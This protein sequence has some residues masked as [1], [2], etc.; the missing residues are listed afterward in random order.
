MFRKFRLP[1]IRPRRSPLYYPLFA[2][3]AVLTLGVLYGC[4][5]VVAAQQLAAA[6]RTATLRNAGTSV[7][8]QQYQPQQ[9]L[10]ALTRPLVL[11]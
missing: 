2:I 11:N 9:E 7:S 8:S 3:G 5:D 10:A 1:P 6:P 4:K